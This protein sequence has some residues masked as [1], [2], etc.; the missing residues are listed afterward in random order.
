[1]ALQVY[2]TNHSQISDD[3]LLEMCKMAQ[4]HREQ[5]LVAEFEQVR[6]EYLEQLATLRKIYANKFDSLL[7]SIQAIRSVS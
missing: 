3:A 6:A 1:M 4:E 2:V 7:A 5:E